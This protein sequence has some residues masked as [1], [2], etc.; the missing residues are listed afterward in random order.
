MV[1]YCQPAHATAPSACA[2][3]RD[4]HSA[5]FEHLPDAVRR[6][7]ETHPCYSE[8]AHHYFARMHVAV[9]PACNIQ[10][11]YCNRKYDCANESRPGVATEL[12]TPT[13]AV[14]K[15]LAVAAAIPELA[16][17]GIAGPGDPL[18][19]PDRVFATLRMLSEQAP[20]LKLCISTNGLALPDYID[21]LL[22]HNIGHVTITINCVDPTIGAR[23][24]PWIFWKQR[25]LRGREAAEILL[26]R[27]LEGL[28]R[29]VAR[30]VLVKI[31]SVLIP[32]VNDAHLPEVNR[33]VRRKGAFLHNIM[34]LIARPEHGTYFGLTGRREPDIEELQAV[35]ERCGTGGRMMRHCR[36]CRADAVGL[37]GQNRETEFTAAKPAAQ[38]IDYSAAAAKRAQV[39]AA[40][41]RQ[42]ANRRAIREA[43]SPMPAP[44]I[45]P[46]R[47]AVATQS[48]SLID[49]HFGQVQAF[50]LYEAT[51]AGVRLLGRR[52]VAPYCTGPATCDEEKSRLE[53]ALQ[54]LQGCDVLLCA[55]I[56]I[57]PWKGLEAAGIQPDSEHAM[58]PIEDAIVAVYQEWL[59][60][61]RLAPVT[62]R[63]RG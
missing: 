63:L 38:P 3:T 19:N 37:L 9:A 2:V 24:Y 15:A 39:H 44:S 35:R 18:A 22:A 28:E 12:L 8:D 13:Q 45:R 21:E 59:T 29:L 42:L 62:Q 11:H 23:I 1:A 36:Q 32:G 56:G 43:Q 5:V 20:D 48:D 57:I 30:D 27:Q 25:R 26:A 46:L 41:R 51:S 10:C 52:A 14:H 34:P 58:E 60:A 16:V 17:V 53:R 31:N 61:G 33:V 47:V 55:K 50:L 49:A 54:A 6:R 7:I 40:I 4:D